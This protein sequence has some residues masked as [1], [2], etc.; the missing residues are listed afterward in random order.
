MAKS[1]GS[2]PMTAG[3]RSL[4][5][6]KGQDG[7]GKRHGKKGVWYENGGTK[8]GVPAKT[9]SWPTGNPPSEVAVLSAAKKV[10]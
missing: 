9:G 4:K 6:S 1:K 5:R 3:G 10:S 8:Y 2:R 7:G